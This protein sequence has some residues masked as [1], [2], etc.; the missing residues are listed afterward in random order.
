VLVEVEGLLFAR[1]DRREEV[2]W[3]ALLGIES[4]DGY[5]VDVV[6][7]DIDETFATDDAP[8]EPVELT[9]R[10]TADGVTLSDQ[11][12][13]EL[14]VVSRSEPGGDVPDALTA[15]VTSAWARWDGARFDVVASP[16]SSND[17]VEVAA[18]GDRAIAVATIKLNAGA[19]AW[20]TGD[21]VHWEPAVLPVEPSDASPLPITI[22]RNEVALSISDGTT[23]RN[24]SEMQLFS[25]LKKFRF[26]FHC[27]I[28]TGF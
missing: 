13:R 22:G 4:G 11:D 7:D 23:T 17:I 2:D 12:G 15:T 9:A 3:R 18:V 8:A 1:L 24:I 6:G 14:G 10:A 5:R 27:I 28:Y 21:G 26:H 20:T 19:R 16:W 25:F